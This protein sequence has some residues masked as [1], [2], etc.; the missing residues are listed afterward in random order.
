[1]E[2]AQVLLAEEHCLQKEMFAHKCMNQ[3]TSTFT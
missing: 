1:M 3:V 2:I